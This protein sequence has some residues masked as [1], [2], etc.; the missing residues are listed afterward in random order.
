MHISAGVLMTTG[1][2]K[3]SALCNARTI[4]NFK[5]FK[6]VVFA[7]LDHFIP[8]F[9][10]ARFLPCLLSLSNLQQ[11]GGRST[12]MLTVHMCV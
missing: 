8:Q 5:T 6:S 7:L 1:G 9:Q 10:V 12:D 11:V 4:S 3:K 2:S